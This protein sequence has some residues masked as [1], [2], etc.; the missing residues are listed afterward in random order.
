MGF[1]AR[2]QV[3]TIIGAPRDK[4]SDL[5][6]VNNQ[7]DALFQCVYLL[8]E[9]NCVNVSS[10]KHHSVLGENYIYQIMY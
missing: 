2:N 3:R 10:G 1:Q 8:G 6:F 9:S 5:I 7:R 4:G